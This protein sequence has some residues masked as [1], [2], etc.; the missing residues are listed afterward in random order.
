[1]FQSQAE[2]LIIVIGLS[3]LAVVPQLFYWLQDD[4]LDLI[5]VQVDDNFLLLVSRM[6]LKF[7]YLH[8]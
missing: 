7:S 1:M 6:P 4:A 2:Y 8:H 5:I 3:H